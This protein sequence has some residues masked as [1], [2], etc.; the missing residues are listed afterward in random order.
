MGTSSLRTK[1]KD[2]GKKK[3]QNKTAEKISSEIR[4][5][6]CGVKGQKCIERFVNSPLNNTKESLST[7]CKK[8]VPKELSNAR[9]LISVNRQCR[10]NKRA[11]VV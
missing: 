4:R 11:K 7:A 2:A 5:G 10:G 9:P 3:Q 8:W 1:T 6:C